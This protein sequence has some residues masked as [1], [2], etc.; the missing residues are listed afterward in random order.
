[1]V[2]Q[3]LSERWTNIPRMKITQAI[4]D[5]VLNW[6][7]DLQFEVQRMTAAGGWKRHEPFHWEGKQGPPE[8][9]DDFLIVDPGR[10]REI[11]RVDGRIHSVL[12][13][14]ETAESQA[15]YE[16]QKQHA[17]REKQ[18]ELAQD[19]SKTELLAEARDPDQ[20]DELE[21]IEILDQ[22]EI[23]LRDQ[24]REMNAG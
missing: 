17:K 2:G 14:Y 4:H 11:R 12:W 20:L 7:R 9:D 13:T 21:P 3:S 10:Y 23:M 5:W 8:D 22:L 15:Y 16:K 19:L 18:L 6:R 1:M 24:G